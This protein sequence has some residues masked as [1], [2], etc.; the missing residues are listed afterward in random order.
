MQPNTR[1]ASTHS[2]W[3][4]VG[5]WFGQEETQQQSNDKNA[6]S[7]NGGCRRNLFEGRASHFWREQVGRDE[8]GRG[9]QHPSANVRRKAAP[10][11]AQVKGKGSGQV[12]PEIAKLRDSHKPT[13]RHAPLKKGRVVP[14]QVKIGQGQ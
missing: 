3:Q 14:E 12:F 7:N 13:D 9:S 2:L 8:R 6:G 10:G 4:L 1:E 11:S 5:L